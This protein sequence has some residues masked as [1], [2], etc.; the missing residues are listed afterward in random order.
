MLTKKGHTIWSEEDI[1]R[2]LYDIEEE[3]DG[4]REEN[5][6]ETIQTEEETTNE[7]K[8]KKVPEPKEKIKKRKGR[9]IKNK[10]EEFRIL[11]INDE[12][13]KCWMPGE[14]EA[15][16]EKKKQRN[17]EVLRD[18]TNMSRDMPCLTW[19][20]DLQGYSLPGIAALLFRMISK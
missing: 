16:E 2:M 5:E 15:D 17:E 12:N 14:G 6:K 11:E 20:V 8:E 4:K 9:T 7:K 19:S 3:K 1:L 13:V 10:N 18:G